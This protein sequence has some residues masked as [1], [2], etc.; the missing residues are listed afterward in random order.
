AR[1]RAEGDQLQPAGLQQLRQ[2]LRLVHVG[3][4]EFD[5]AEAGTSG[6][7]E[8]FEERDFAKQVREIRA[9]PWHRT[10]TGRGPTSTA[11][12]RPRSPRLDARSSVQCDP[13]ML[14]RYWMLRHVRQALLANHAF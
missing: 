8:T 6:L 5:G 11:L 7:R 4:R 1:G 9:K 14:R 12:V 10:S 3:E 2:A 13:R